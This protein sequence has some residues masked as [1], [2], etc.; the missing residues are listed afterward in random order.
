MRG[1][2]YQLPNGHFLLH[3]LDVTVAPGETLVLLGRSGAGKSTA[4][5]LINRMLEL[6]QGEILG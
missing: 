5:K 2:S 1:A 4:L 6:S 3:G